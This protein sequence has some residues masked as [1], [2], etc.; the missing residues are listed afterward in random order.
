M[1]HGSCVRDG[2]LM[3]S[4]DHDDA[5]H[6]EIRDEHGEL[7]EPPEGV[8]YSSSYT[9]LEAGTPGFNP[10]GPHSCVFC[11]NSDWRWVLEI[12]P[13][14]RGDELAWAPFL[15]ACETCQQLYLSGRLDEL[16]QR[17]EQEGDDWLL[18]VSDQLLERIIAIERRRRQL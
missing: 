18:E 17:I 15:V 13:A 7:V 11:G 4:P 6:V 10:S 1:G 3:I 16:R 14:A 9:P 2:K 5:N 8:S 12:R